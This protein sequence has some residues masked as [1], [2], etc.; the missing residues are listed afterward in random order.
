MLL[1]SEVGG[2][3]KKAPSLR[4]VSLRLLLV[5][6]SLVFCCLLLEVFLRVTHL[7]PDFFW[8]LDSE[9][10]A[11]H[12]PGK[13]GWA[14][15][16]GGRQYVQ[17]NSL[18]YRDR[19]RSVHKA[20]GTFRI[21]LL[22]DSFVEAFQVSQDDTLAAILERRLN[23]D[24]SGPAARFEVLNFGVSGFGTAEELETFR[25]RASRFQPDLV[26]LN[27]YTSNDLYDNSPELDPEPNRLRYALGPH[28]E[29]M[30]L[31][32]RV[33]D[34]ALKRWLRAHSYA[35][36]LVRDRIK[37]FGA[38]RKALAAMS[39]MQD[40]VDAAS[41][42]RARQ[43]LT[44]V[45]YLRQR[46][47]AV[48]RAWQLTEALIAEFR[49]ESRKRSAGFAVIVIPNKEEVL[50]RD[51]A[52]NTDPK[53]DYQQSLRT[54]DKVCGGLGIEC[55]QLA[56]VFRAGSVDE[57]YFPLDGHWTPKGHALGA[58]ATFEWLRRSNLVSCAGDTHRQTAS[59]P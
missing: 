44:G 59:L 45:Q 24:C 42:Q 16:R 15:F 35:Y 23:A 13:K 19:E 58:G 56:D 3:V 22:G 30:R 52:T 6:A 54:I 47:P 26:L 17:I 9:V 21:A 14:V 39:M 31:S 2:Q 5:S 34:N 12:I 4:A 57:L 1:A 33:S 37:T 36:L 41:E 50:T 27:L 25:H 29:L 20:E 53:R 40:Q 8:Q 10:G 38:L 32:F 11:T 49:L 51:S 7:Q 28:G 46:P 48:E 55:L 43:A 18:G